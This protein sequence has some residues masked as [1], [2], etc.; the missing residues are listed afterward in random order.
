MSNFQ[1]KLKGNYGLGAYF[2]SWSSNWTA[3]AASSDLSNIDPNINIIYLS[4]VT[5]AC[6]YEKDSKK[7]IGTGLDFS[8]EFGIIQES[9]KILKEKGVIVMLSVGGATFTF[10]VFNPIN[11]NNLVIDLG[12]D[13]VDL[14]WEDVQGA[15]AG[16]KLSQI[17]QN[18]R[19]NLDKDLLLSLAAFSTGA[20]GFDEFE[21]ALPKSQ[22]TGMC[23]QGIQNSGHLLDWINIMSYDAGV[24]Y[25]PIIAFKSYRKYFSKPL[26]LGIE[27]PPEAWGG[28]IITLKDVE[29]YV[30]CILDDE[31]NNN[32]IFVWSY[33]KT[34]VP[35]CSNIIDE[36]LN[37]FKSNPSKVITGWQNGVT[38]NAGENVI[39]N[40][41]SYLCTTTHPSTAYSKPGVNLW[42]VKNTTDKKNTISNKE[43]HIKIWK[44]N[45][46][47]NAEQIV[48][49]D[50]K[51]YKCLTTHTSINTWFPSNENKSL[52]QQLI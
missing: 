15:I 10:D 52:W 6:S 20:Y 2:C 30:N 36:C 26:I 40:G 23:I 39:Y 41:E 21:N 7:W 13:G 5:P 42:V 3:T 24:N 1:K 8:S 14:D 43:S 35:S 12:C 31:Q 11:I 34:G 9:I 49:Y 4:F 45:T 50:S 29:K 32:G 19:E 33:K 18:M 27:V 38:Y 28:H 22:N 51:L 17:I 25:D 46:E 47:Y 37:V 48:S 44:E 16:P